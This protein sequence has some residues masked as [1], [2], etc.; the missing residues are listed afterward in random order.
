MQGSAIIHPLAD[1][2]Y[3]FPH[4]AD[5]LKPLRAPF[6]LTPRDKSDR[7]N[8]KSHATRTSVVLVPLAILL[9]R[10]EQNLSLPVSKMHFPELDSLGCTEQYVAERKHK[11]VVTCLCSAGIG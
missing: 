1:R 3:F 5:L 4:C 2:E 9:S 10:R 8:A 11:S 6:K 7:S